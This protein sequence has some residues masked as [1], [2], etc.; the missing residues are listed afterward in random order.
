MLVNFND[1]FDLNKVYASWILQIILRM[2]L[3]YKI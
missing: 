1:D 3:A 2:F